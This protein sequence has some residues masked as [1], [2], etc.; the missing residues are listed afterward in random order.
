MVLFLNTGPVKT[1]TAYCPFN[2]IL[3][4]IKLLTIFRL[5]TYFS[6]CPQFAGEVFSVL[7]KQMRKLMGGNIDLSYPVLDPD[8]F[9]VNALK[10]QEVHRQK[11]RQN[12][13]DGIDF[14]TITRNE[15]SNKT[16]S[17]LSEQNRKLSKAYFLC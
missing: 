3:G 8:D 16:V 7:A 10:E 15:S 1:G 11:A 14:G 2:R 5:V 12:G 4:V 6:T 9:V 13:M 17:G